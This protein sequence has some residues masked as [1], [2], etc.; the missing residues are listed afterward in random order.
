VCQFC[1]KNAV[2]RTAVGIW[3]CRS[4]RKTT[5]GGAYTVAYV[6]LYSAHI[7]HFETKNGMRDT[8]WKDEG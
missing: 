4:C 2:K 3:N 6:I 7:L 8:R 1:G 5:A